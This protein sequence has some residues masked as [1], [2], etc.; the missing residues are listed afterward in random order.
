M[1]RSSLSSYWWS[2]CLEGWE[3]CLSRLTSYLALSWCL[4]WVRG[5]M[6]MVMVKVM[7]MMVVVVVIIITQCKSWEMDRRAVKCSLLDQCFLTHVALWHFN[8]VSHVVVTPTLKLFLLLLHNYNFATV[9][10][11]N[12][13]IYVFQWSWGTPVKALFNT[14]P[15]GSWAVGWES[16]LYIH[17]G[18]RIHS[19]FGNLC[20]IKTIRSV[21]I[22]LGKHQLN[23]EGWY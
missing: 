5:M 1:D 20:K 18:C 7:V 10:N 4:L 17:H 2:V 6:V 13:N 8:P 14:H 22:S 3:V 9:M 21:N 15:K 23:S 19:S 16:L 11:H 12:V